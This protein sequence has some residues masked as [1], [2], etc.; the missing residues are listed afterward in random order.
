MSQMDDYVAKNTN[1]SAEFKKEYEKATL[2]FEIADMIFD[3]REEMGLNQ[4]EFAKVVKKPR[5]TIARIENATM[6]P[7][8]TLLNEIL[9]SLG[10][11]VEI[12]VVERSK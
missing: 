3:V 4:T 10:K 2:Q 12:K 1:E 6:E 7:S 8:L 5:S 11:Q 9:N